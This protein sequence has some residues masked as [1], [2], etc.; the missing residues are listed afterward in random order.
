MNK[1]IEELAK[2]AELDLEL[3]SLKV[4]RFAELIIAELDKVLMN[5]FYSDPH[6]IPNFIEDVKK[7][8]GV[9]DD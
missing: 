3:Q 1:R 4:E 7:H 8:F 9:R 2:H 6:E 5:N